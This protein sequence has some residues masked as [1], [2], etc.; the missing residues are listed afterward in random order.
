[1]SE[2]VNDRNAPPTS[3]AALDRGL[4]LALREIIAAER[5]LPCG[6]ER[7]QVS[8]WLHAI[9]VGIRAIEKQLLGPYV[10]RAEARP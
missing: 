2:P 9:V 3:Q 10:P 6:P 8:A 4:A 1:M 7:D 5:E